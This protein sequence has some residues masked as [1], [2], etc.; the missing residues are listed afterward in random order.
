MLWY[1]L[2]QIGRL[3]R[4]VGK[5]SS[6]VASER[7]K[8]RAE[9][10]HNI[11]QARRNGKSPNALQIAMG[12]LFSEHSIL[13]TG[14]NYILP[15]I[16]IIFLISVIRYGTGLQYALSVSVGGEELGIIQNESEFR[17]GM[18]KTK[19]AREFL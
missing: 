6:Q 13:R 8:A 16:S 12:Y 4:F 18:Q 15:V 11:H 14:F 2:R 1:M 3:F 7:R 19:S 17:N 9:V 5:L 10:M